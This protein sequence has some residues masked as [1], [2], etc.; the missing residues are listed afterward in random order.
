MSLSAFLGIQDEVMSSTGF[1]IKRETKRRYHYLNI[2]DSCDQQP[3][4][5]PEEIPNVLILLTLQLFLL[6]LKNDITIVKKRQ[7]LYKV[8]EFYYIFM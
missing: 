6:I 7:T 5:V 8:T 1:Q 4:I 3:M 2:I